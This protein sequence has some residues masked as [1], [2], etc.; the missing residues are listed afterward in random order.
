MTSM[1]FCSISKATIS[2]WKHLLCCT[3][4]VFYCLVY[5]V[6]NEGSNKAHSYW[7]QYDIV[8]TAEFKHEK[9]LV[10]EICSFHDLSIW[11]MKVNFLIRLCTG[12]YRITFFSSITNFKNIIHLFDE[13]HWIFLLSCWYFMSDE[14]KELSIFNKVAD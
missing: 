12:N 10:P 5:S 8:I 4:I 7:I 13:F 3:V 11:L 9:N 2:F 6:G 1:S 14:L